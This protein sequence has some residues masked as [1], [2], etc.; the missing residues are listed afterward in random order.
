M[1]PKGVEVVKAPELVELAKA[2]P[3]EK[4]MEALLKEQGPA[5]TFFVPSR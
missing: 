4:A 5:Q 3:T 1:V 2:I